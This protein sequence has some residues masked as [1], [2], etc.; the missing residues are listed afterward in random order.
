MIR[1][2]T[3]QGNCHLVRGTCVDL[4]AFQLAPSART[5][6]G[7]GMK[8]KRTSSFYGRDEYELSD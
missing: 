6:N 1:M 3:A 4:L 5:F 7:S 2:H 8:L